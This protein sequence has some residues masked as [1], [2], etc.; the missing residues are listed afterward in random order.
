MI[1]M[2]IDITGLSKREIN[3]LIQ[4]MIQDSNLS[5]DEIIQFVKDKCQTI[6]LEPKTL[7]MLFELYVGIEYDSDDELT[8]F[9]NYI[10]IDELKTN[11]HPEFETSNGSTWARTDRNY[12]GKKYKIKKKP[13]TGKTRCVKL[14][15]PNKDSVKKFRNIREDIKDTIL[16]QRCRISGATRWRR[17]SV[18]TARKRA[19]LSNR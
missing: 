19:S 16:K 10:E 14:D 6:H 13:K 7:G 3:K 2:D 5:S 4:N 18:R 15:G 17:I 8:Y 12:L 11:I 1:V 9:T